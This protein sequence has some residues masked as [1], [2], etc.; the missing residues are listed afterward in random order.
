MLGELVAINGRIFKPNDAKISVFD[1]GFL[2][3]DSV[4]EV[5][6]S[7]GG[8]FF[9]LEDHMERMFNSARLISLDLE[10]HEREYLAEIYRVAHEAGIQD[11]YMRVVVSR[12]EGAINLDPTSVHKTTVVIYIKKLDGMINPKF[13]KEGLD[14]ITAKVR[15]NTS[16]SLD[17]NIKSGNYLNN[18]M[19]LGEAKKKKA[20]DAILLNHDGEVTE[21]TTW[22][23]FM[24]KNKTVYTSPDGCGILH[25]ITRSKIKKICKENKIKF[26]E[27]LFT[28]EDVYKADEAFSSGSVKEIMAI[29]SLDG[30]KIGEG[31]PGEITL[32]IAKLY[33]DY[34][35]DYCDTFRSRVQI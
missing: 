9:A 15:R 28:P 14:I 32:K 27:K 10:M 24:I 33:S 29:R 23:F 2:Y 22:N 35:K 3:G 13:Y 18:I 20:N 25:G 31:V 26:V 21:G 5:A 16:D 17:P 12:G 1:R 7:Y 34:V 19:A 30:K 8:V 4:Y 11:A 6:R